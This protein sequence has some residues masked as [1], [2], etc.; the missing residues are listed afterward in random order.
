MDSSVSH[1]VIL[2][3]GKSQL[4]G[5]IRVSTAKQV[6]G[7][8][9]DAQRELLRTYCEG[10]EHDLVHIFADEGI[11][12][13]RGVDRPQYENLIRRLA[14][15]HDVQGVIV[16]SLSR[17]GRSLQD[18]IAFVTQLQAADRVFISIK[19]HFDLTTKEGRMMMGMMAVVN[20][21]ERE[22]ISERMVEGREWAEIH[23]T[24]SGKPCHR[25]RRDINWPLI[26]RMRK[27]SLSWGT[28]SK[29]LSANPDTKISKSTLIERA[30]ERGLKIA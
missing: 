16:C 7:T 10:E 8:S 2:R 25:P 20:E 29:A 3:G 13:K 6:E 24:K 23:G 21:Y 11:S 9:L 18:V 26:E 1:E 15:D 19:E 22:L 4:V 14:S 5:Y 12:G 30:R 27:E 17:L 28:I